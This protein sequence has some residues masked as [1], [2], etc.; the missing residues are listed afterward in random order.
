MTYHTLVLVLGLL[1]LPVRVIG[2]PPELAGTYAVWL[3]R[4]ECTVS[5]TSAAPVAGYLVLGEDTLRTSVFSEETRRQLR[6]WSGFLTFEFRRGNLPPNACFSLRRRTSNVG[7]MAGIIPAGFTLWR[8]N[9]GVL[10]VDLYA[11]PDAA[12]TLSA[13]VDGNALLGVGRDHGVIG[14]PFDR[15][16]GTAHGVRVGPPD[17]TVCEP[18]RQDP[19]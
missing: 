10:S 15:Q 17:P 8:M 19:V 18:Q 6:D 16:V 5:D 9:G 7:L 3:C 4:G 11:S 12:Y 14:Q 2:Q 13:S 1:L